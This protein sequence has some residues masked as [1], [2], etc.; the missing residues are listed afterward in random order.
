[1]IGIVGISENRKVTYILI[2][3][4]KS[5]SIIN[6]GELDPFKIFTLQRL[7]GRLLAGSGIERRFK[8]N[9]ML[10]ALPILYPAKENAIA[11]SID[12]G[13]KHLNQYK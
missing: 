1:L 7:I 3:L 11:M 13:I 6:R 4:Y 5:F 9:L 8:G 10:N 2:S 12:V